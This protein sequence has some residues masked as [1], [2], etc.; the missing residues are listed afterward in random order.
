MP[1]IIKK[2]VVKKKT[3]QEEEVKSVALQA[4][5]S[6]RKKQKQI[7]IGVS[8]LI[9]IL[10]LLFIFSL[11]SSSQH[12]KAYLIELEA[13]NYYYGEK[14]D[15]SLSQVDRWKKAIELYQQSVD[16][17]ATPTALY[18]LGNCYFNLSDYENAIKQYNIFAEK[19]GGNTKIL[20][21]VY[22]KLASS[23]FKT[24]QNDLALSTLGKLGNVANGIFKDTAL[25]FEARYYDA[26]GESGKAMEIY[27]VLAR[28]FPASPWAAEANSKISA[29]EAEN[30]IKEKEGDGPVAK[31]AE[32]QVQ[33]EKRP[34]EPAVK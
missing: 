12:E 15:K 10:A 29:V 13:T 2:K 4:V 24:N 9:F 23:Y 18:Y 14:V 3:K 11:Y 34:E 7:I 19:F 5:E 26:A 6:L 33:E 22:Q 25:I 32:V 20:P 27:T 21:L 17:K 1:K 8:V 31:E 30:A 28:D 16:L